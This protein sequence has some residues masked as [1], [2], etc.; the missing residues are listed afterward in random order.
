LRAEDTAFALQVLWFRADIIFEKV[1]IIIKAWKN[2]YVGEIIN[3]KSKQSSVSGGS[4]EMMRI[5]RSFYIVREQFKNN[6]EGS[7]T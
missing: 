1:Y 4:L 6:V 5:Q 3:L 2:Y 7:K